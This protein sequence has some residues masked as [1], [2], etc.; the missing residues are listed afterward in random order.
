MV[1]DVVGMALIA[2]LLVLVVASL[3]V[4]PANG[5]A[6]PRRPQFVPARRRPSA[7]WLSVSTAVKALS[8]SRL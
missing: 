1:G 4:L 7:A 2:V 5:E 6:A 3:A 8:L